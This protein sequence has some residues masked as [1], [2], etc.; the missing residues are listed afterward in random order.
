[1]RGV[2]QVGRNV[3]AYACK[4]KNNSLGGTSGNQS[5]KKAGVVAGV[6]SSIDP[7]LPWISLLMSKSSKVIVF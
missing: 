4:N 5:Q 2:G 7:S 6:Y 3:R 1:V